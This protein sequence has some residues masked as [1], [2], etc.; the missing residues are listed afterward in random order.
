MNRILIVKTSSLG[1]V[2]HNL[3]VINDIKAHYPHVSID[4]IVEESFADIPRL[5]NGV[6]KIFVVAIRRWRKK[7]FSKKT[8]QEMSEFKHS[9]ASQLPYDLILD[10]QGLIKSALIASFAIGNK[11]GM[12]KQSAREP[13]ASYFYK[14]KY[15]VPRAQHA[16]KRN[17][18]LAAMACGYTIPNDAPD[19]GIKKH[20]IA[21]SV[22]ESSVDLGLKKPYIVGLHGTS[23]DSKLWPIDHWVTLGKTLAQQ[24]L[25]LALPWASSAEYQRAL[26]IADSLANVMVLPKQTI[27][28]LAQIISQAA[29]T[30]GVDTGLSHLATALNIPTIAIYT[31]TN[32]ELTGVYPGRY[33][34]AKNIGGIAQIPSS[35]EVLAA[36]MRIYSY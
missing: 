32:P 9:I 4:W 27:A 24:N 3:P 14:K 22:D 26:Q 23:R 36:L 15:H 17:R 7:L 28:Q 10:T 6:N 33:A 8:W 13:L 5:H 31:D 11:H 25:T 1:D 2:I 34:P 21:N 29:A 19:Y 18:A 12:D 20:G 30:I 35:K 16:V